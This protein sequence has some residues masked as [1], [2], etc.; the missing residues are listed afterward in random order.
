[1]E[2]ANEQPRNHCA[3]HRHPLKFAIMGI[4][5][6]LLLITAVFMVF[7]AQNEAKKGRYIG[8]DIQVKNTIAVSGE[9]KILA[10]PDIGKVSLTVLSESKTV[11]AAQKDNT[12]KMN[13]TTQAMKDLGVDGKDL[14][15][16]NYNIYPNYQY[17][18][19]KSVIIGYQ[20]SQT[21]DVK[22]RQLDKASAI[23]AKAAENGVNQIGSL[24]FAIDNPESIKAEARKKAIDDA[25]QKADALKNDLGVSLIRIVSFFESS[26][27]P[28]TPYYADKAYG[29][30]GGGEAPTPE[31]QAGQNEIVVNVTITYEIN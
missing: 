17:I 21:L 31:V 29:I 12:E 23:L 11:A 7:A 2:N 4:F 5:A 14:K 19:G 18:A 8:Q 20:V 25:K 27:Q 28:P 22:I 1:M 15:T 26:S 30:G 16:T 6:A 9:G 10:K 24:S 13:K 3:G